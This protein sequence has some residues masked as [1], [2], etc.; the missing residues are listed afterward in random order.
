MALLATDPQWVGKAPPHGTS[1]KTCLNALCLMDLRSCGEWESGHMPSVCFIFEVFT[2]FRQT[3]S[4]YFFSAPSDE[5][6]F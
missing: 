4:H 6:Y 3:V 2:F 5:P 1:Q